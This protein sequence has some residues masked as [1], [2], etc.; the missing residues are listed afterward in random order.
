MSSHADLRKVSRI[1]NEIVP[2][3][4]VDFTRVLPRVLSLYIFSYL[5]P[6]SLCRAAQVS[7][8]WKLLSES[9][10]LWA[11]KCQQLGW[12]LPNLGIYQENGV[13][14]RIYIEH[15]QYL[16]VSQSHLMNLELKEVRKNLAHE[17]KNDRDK[18]EKSRRKQ[19]LPS[20]DNQVAWSSS[21]GHQ[22]SPSKI[23]FGKRSSSTI[24]KSCEG[25][26]I[27]KSSKEVAGPSSVT[28][29]TSMTTG[30]KNKRSTIAAV[31][32]RL[33]APLERRTN[34]AAYH[35]PILDIIR[36]VER[37]YLRKSTENYKTT[38]AMIVAPRGHRFV[39]LTPEDV[40]ALPSPPA[41]RIERYEA[42][43]FEVPRNP[44]TRQAQIFQL[45]K[46]VPT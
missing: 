26:S 27:P 45:I 21:N 42:K 11:L 17:E 22:T 4:A 9:N 1:I 46:D 5:D 31:T 13:C 16:R 19:R 29:T 39:A 35:P 10:S 14:K 3:S 18:E 24:S 2:E 7:W 37:L 44:S 12:Q 43:E 30:S 20:R 38:T 6:R 23:V 33:S 41:Y 32:E 36:S 40:R 15:M 28:S 8:Y 34:S 25:R